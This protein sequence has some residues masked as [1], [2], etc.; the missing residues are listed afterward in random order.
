[1]VVSTDWRC[2]VAQ[3]DDRDLSERLLGL[4]KPVAARRRIASKL[5]LSTIFSTRNNSFAH[6]Q[7]RPNAR[8]VRVT[9]KN[10]T[11]LSEGRAPNVVHYSLEAM[12]P[13][14]V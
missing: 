6:E 4:G 10:S 8:V 14:E 11:L 1:M 13:P 9:S 2:C 3:A 5:D 12:L 7:S